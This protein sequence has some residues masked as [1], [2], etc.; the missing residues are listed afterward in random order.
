MVS[1]LLALSSSV[2]WGVSDFLGGFLSRRVALVAVL[3]ITQAV[4]LG[5][6][7]PLA[8][9]HAAPVLDVPAIAFAVGGSAS[10]LIGIAALYRGMGVGAVSIV[11]PISATGAALPVLF[12]VLRGERATPLQSLG[13]GLALVGIVLASRAAAEPNS[14]SRPMVAR[15][16]GLALVAA[17]GFGGFFVL[18]HEA[19]V[20]DV[21]WATVVQRLTG[22]CLM[23]V[24]ALV[25]RPSLKVG[26]TRVPSLLLVG[27]LDTGANVL[28]AYASTL[29][30]VSLAAVLASLFPVVTVILAWIVLKER[31]SMSQGTG[32]VCALTGVALIASQ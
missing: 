5:L 8:M 31:L 14:V 7:L 1:V 29:G 2:A 15:G 16:V 22:L 13:I 28:Y 21:L 27:A 17:L 26:W 20:R 25:L 30:L 23:T 4:G 24:A 10:G 18:L 32:V 9:L 11:A 19:S 12:G 6:M 3:L